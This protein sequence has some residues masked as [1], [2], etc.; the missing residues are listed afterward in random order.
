MKRDDHLLRATKIPNLQMVKACQSER[1]KPPVVG[2]IAG[3]SAG[4]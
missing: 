4:R 3:S 1:F 2:D